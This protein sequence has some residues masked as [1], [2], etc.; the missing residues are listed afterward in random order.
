MT[1]IRFC[2]DAAGRYDQIRAPSIPWPGSCQHQQVSQNEH[3]NDR[4]VCE[5]RTMHNIRDPNHYK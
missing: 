1:Q 4:V 3:I 5:N 2:A